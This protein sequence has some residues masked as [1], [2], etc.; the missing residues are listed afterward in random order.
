MLAEKPEPLIDSLVSYYGSERHR[1]APSKP[2]GIPEHCGCGCGRAGLNNR[3]VREQTPPRQKRIAFAVS[4]DDFPSR[5]SNAIS[6]V[7]WA[8][9]RAETYLR[10]RRRFSRPSRFVERTNASLLNSLCAIDGNSLTASTRPS[11]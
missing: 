4:D 10:L 11:R 8:F 1:T 5:I 7:L 2:F 6:N 9:C 3:C